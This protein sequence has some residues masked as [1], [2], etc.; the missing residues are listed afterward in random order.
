MARISSVFS[1][2]LFLSGGALLLIAVL[3]LVGFIQALVERLQHGPGLLFADVEIL[4]FI[5][6]ICALLGAA[7]LFGARKLSKHSQSEGPTA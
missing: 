2:I 4:G 1:T 7:A 3:S 6:F 5:T